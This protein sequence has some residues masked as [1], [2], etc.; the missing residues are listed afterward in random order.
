MKHLHVFFALI[1]TIQSGSS[2]CQTIGASD[3]IQS[4]QLKE[5]L[6]VIASDT[7]E[8]RNTPSRGLDSTARYIAGQL[9]QWGVRPAGDEGTYFQNMPLSIKHL[10]VDSSFVEI[11]GERLSYG[12]YI[13]RSGLE[14]VPAEV[15]GNVVYV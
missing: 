9:S 1:L 7:M 11:N 12:Y 2:F 3:T 15:S 4:K 8:G 5:Y 6:S 13:F 10:N 14:V